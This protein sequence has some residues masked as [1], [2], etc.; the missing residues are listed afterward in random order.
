MTSYKFEVLLKRQSGKT[1]TQG[2]EMLSSNDRY[3]PQVKAQITKHLRNLAK[4]SAK[5]NKKPFSKDNPCELH[6]DVHPPTKARMDAP[7][8]YPTI[9]ALVDGLV[10][11][12][13]L[14]EDNNQIIK[15]TI[16]ESTQLSGVKQTYRIVMTL[17]PLQ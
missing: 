4:M 3:H 5:Y 12:H 16:F 15:R 1:L 17:I 9:K 7:N 2:N 6:I 13:V 11:K 10:D 14:T 8:V